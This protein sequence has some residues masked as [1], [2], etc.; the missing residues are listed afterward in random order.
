MNEA[1]KALDRIED[2]LT[3]FDPD[4]PRDEQGQWTDAGITGPATWRKTPHGFSQWGIPRG[5]SVGG[6]RECWRR[7]ARMEKEMAP[8]GQSQW[9]LARRRENGTP[10]W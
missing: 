10:L 6:A 2:I 4:Q 9:P 8:R 5:S 7:A 1:L 3:R